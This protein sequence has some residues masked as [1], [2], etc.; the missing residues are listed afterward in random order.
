MHNAIARSHPQNYSAR[1][2]ELEEMVRER[3]ETIR[4]FRLEFDS[5]ARIAKKLELTRSERVCLGVL[6]KLERASF[7]TLM[8]A[9]YDGS[10]Y[11]WRDDNVVKVFVCKLRRKLKSVG[12]SVNNDW[13]I[14]YYLSADHK[15]LIH[16]LLDEPA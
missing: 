9:L 3:D 8:A 16:A 2:E 1:I 5:G 13:G 7:K 11:E 10:S 15:S 4:L 14:G 6:M 12:V